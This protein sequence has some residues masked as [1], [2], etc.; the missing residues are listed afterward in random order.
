MSSFLWSR[1]S[2]IRNYSSSSLLVWT[3]SAALQLHLSHH[4]L[5]RHSLRRYRWYLGSSDLAPMSPEDPD[6]GVH[7][8]HLT[9]KNESTCMWSTN[10]I[11][12]RRHGLKLQAPRLFC[13]HLM[14]S[15]LTGDSPNLTLVSSLLRKS[16][17]IP[18]IRA[19]WNSCWTCRA[20]LHLRSTWIRA[21]RHFTWFDQFQTTSLNFLTFSSN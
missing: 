5:S 6:Q 7:F 14:R 15:K 1:L 11:H 19:A 13:S 20:L 3:S 8:S 2:A 9:L 4:W 16:H 17:R 12:T 18:S 10:M 21:A